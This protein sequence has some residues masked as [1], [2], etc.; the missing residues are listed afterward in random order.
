M[1]LDFTKMHGAGNDYVYVLGVDPSGA[2]RKLPEDAPGL[3]RRLSSRRFSIGSDGLV[4]VIRGEQSPWRMRIWNAD[5]SEA[6]MCGNAIRCVAK[7]LHDRGLASDETIAIETGNGVLPVTVSLAGGKVASATV[8][9]GIPVVTRSGKGDRFGFEPST[10]IQLGDERVVGTVVSMGNPHFVLFDEDL[11]DARVSR[12]GPLLERHPFFP[13]RT[14]VEFVKVEAGDRLRVRVWE[15]GSGET[16][17][18]GTGACAAFAAVSVAG[19]AVAV[20]TVSLPG[21]DLVCEWRSHDQPML[22]TGPCETAFEG[23][24]EV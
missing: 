7:L 2:D 23:W 16:L 8:G 4:Y 22:L 20:G 9:M 19:R 11:S 12:L 15:R 18:C 1:R 6:E 17:A 24:V 13:N 14:N 21:G 5:G 3:A 10:E